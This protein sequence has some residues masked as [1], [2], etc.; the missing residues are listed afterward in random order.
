[1]VEGIRAMAGAMELVVRV[2]EVLTLHMG[3]DYV[4]VTVSLEFEDRAGTETLE[5]AIE[6]LD[7][8]IKARYP[9]VKKVFV[10]AESIIRSGPSH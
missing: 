5:R 1:V 4:L 9:D 2:N 8:N 6:E 3:P 7:T 10:E